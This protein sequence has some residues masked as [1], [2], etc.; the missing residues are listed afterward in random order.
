MQS[1]VPYIQEDGLEKV[2]RMQ[3]P[4]KL[5]QYKE[6]ILEISHSPHQTLATTKAGTV[7][8]QKYGHVDPRHA[9]SYLYLLRDDATMEN[10]LLKAAEMDKLTTLAALDT[11]ITKVTEI[12]GKIQKPVEQKRGRQA[13][14][15][16]QKLKK[17]IESR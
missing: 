5:A 14:S 1:S 8:Y 17:Q 10:A 16:L 3:D 2:K 12:V 4:A 11:R 15:Q 6:R 7:L 9:M 13:L